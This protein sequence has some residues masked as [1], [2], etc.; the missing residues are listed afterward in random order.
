MRGQAHSFLVVV[1]IKANQS[2]QTTILIPDQPQLRFARVT[3]LET[4]TIEDLAWGPPTSLPLISA[5]DMPK[6]TL[7][8]NTNNPESNANN[9]LNSPGRFTMTEENFQYLPLASLH[10]IQNSASAPFV[11]QFFEMFNVYPSWDKC[12]LNIA[13]GG[14]GNEDDICV[15]LNVYYSWLTIDN[16]P[17]RR[18]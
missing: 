1:P 15:V 18:N 9:V 11:R 12:K 7:T 6:I 14:L 17:I 13:P 8:L 16:Q 2:T 3:G 10:R 5:T 4:Y